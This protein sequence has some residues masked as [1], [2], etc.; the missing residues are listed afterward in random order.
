MKIN[1][2]NFNSSA[3]T[4]KLYDISIIQ[5]EIGGGTTG[6]EQLKC[7]EKFPDAKSLIVSGLNQESFEYLIKH[8][9]RQF[10]AITFWKNKLVSDLSPLGDLDNLKY[11]HYF[12][13]QRA[14]KLWDM[15]NNESLAGLAIYDFSRL[16]SIDEI[17]S[18][19]NLEYFSIGNRVWSKMEIESLKPLIH[20]SV[21]HFEWCGNKVRD[22][23]FMCLA[24]SRIKELDMNIG[25]FKMDELARLIAAIPGLKGTI[26]TPYWKGSVTEHGVTRT[27][28]YLCK[29]KK[30]LEKGK[31]DEKLEKYLADFER[32]VEKYK[33]K[34]PE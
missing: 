16:H 21:T 23:D 10:E 11:V 4:A 15:K 14:E 3:T 2:S 5:K 17:A 13:N 6:I 29:G 8:F 9:G 34:E 33:V 12:F 25:R 30:S 19:P 1:L 7:I 20:S 24:Q 26:T 31:D 22:N 28:Y 27:W 18:A 32:L